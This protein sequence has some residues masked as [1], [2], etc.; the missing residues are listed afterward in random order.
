VT[1]L[2]PASLRM[3]W[4]M[5]VGP[6]LDLDDR[7]VALTPRTSDMMLI[8]PNVL[9]PGETYT[10]V[11]Q[12]QDNNGIAQSQI[13]VTV[14][15]APVLVEGSLAISM[16]PPDGGI[17]LETP[18]ALATTKDAW[19]DEE[20]PLSY[21][22][23]YFVVGAEDA[24]EVPLNDFQ[25]VADI[26]GVFLPAGLE[27]HGYAVTIVL[28]AMDAMGAESKPVHM[29]ATVAWPA[30]KNEE[31]VSGFA[32][33]KS[34]AADEALANGETDTTLQLVQGITALLNGGMM[35]SAFSSFQ[36]SCSP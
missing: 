13:V 23:S 10:F 21:K 33:K 19:D 28:R 6:P 12:V 1:S 11:L 8:A 31:A 18:F 4:S 14:N 26:S 27:E 7:D 36:F 35:P 30:L 24:E 29:N 34:G 20:L 15:K 22:W 32:D 17:A 3:R 9:V 2:K 25:P 5:L 16:D